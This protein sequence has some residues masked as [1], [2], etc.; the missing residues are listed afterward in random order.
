MGLESYKLSRKYSHSNP[1]KE[2][3]REKQLQVK[4][5]YDLAADREDDT[6]LNGKPFMLSP[7]IFDLKQVDTFHYQITIETIHEKDDFYPGDYLEY[8]GE[9][10]ICFN[11]HSFHK[12]YRKGA[13][14]K[15]NWMLYY[16]TD[17]GEVKRLPCVD[18]NATQYN[19]GEYTSYQKYTLGS[20]QHMLYVQ[21]NSDTV[22]FNDPMRFWLD[23]NLEN[24]TMY[25]VTQN[26][27]TTYNY[28]GSYGLCAITVIQNEWN[29]EKDK[30]I[31]FEDGAQA[32]ICDY[33]DSQNGTAKPGDMNPYDLTATISGPQSLKNGF[34]RK[35]TAMFKDTHG[36]A[37]P[38]IEFE[39][40]VVSDFDVRQIVSGSTIELF[41]SDESCV[42]GSFLLQI[43]YQNTI[44]SEILIQVIEAF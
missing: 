29:T 22:K 31:T 11:S 19:S 24:P 27:N 44:L 30:L 36:T 16:Q 10:W 25:K 17:E 14:R 7:R 18:L 21:C 41:V 5:L 32:W 23:R 8:N 12:L 13:F 35:Y 37:L 2:M 26:D 34:P 9:I 28:R 1:R 15:C 4:A 43:S 20:T 6:L 42:G 33:R 38:D 40:K 39:W 3:L